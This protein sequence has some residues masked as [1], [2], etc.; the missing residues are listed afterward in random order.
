MKLIGNEKFLFADKM[1]KTNMYGWTQERTLVITE[2]NIYNIHKKEIKRTIPI[3]DVSAVIKTVPPSKAK[4]EFTVQVAITYDYR[5]LS[6]RRDEIIE[7]LKKL[8]IVKKNANLPMYYAGTKDLENFTTTEKD[9]EKGVNRWPPN[10]LK[11]NTEDLL[12][13]SASAVKER[14]NTIM[15]SEKDNFE[16]YEAA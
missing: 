6:E 15:T 14:N 13:L 2:E 11:V 16:E 4:T 10:E 7:V 3:K 1:K 12:V 8:F 5:L 9:M